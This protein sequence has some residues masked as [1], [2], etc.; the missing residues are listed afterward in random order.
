MRLYCAWIRILSRLN[1]HAT[2]KLYNVKMIYINIRQL[3]LNSR[4][5][6]SNESI[7]YVKYYEQKAVKGV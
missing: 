7:E 2:F 5:I 1:L 4:N 3:I 6:N